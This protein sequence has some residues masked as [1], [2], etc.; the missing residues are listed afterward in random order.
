MALN[1]PPTS[2]DPRAL[3]RA[4]PPPTPAVPAAQRVTDS[5]KVS[6][7]AA[8]SQQ[9]GGEFKQAASAARALGEAVARVDADTETVGRAAALVAEIAGAPAEQAPAVLARLDALGRSAEGQAAGVDRERLGL[10]GAPGDEAI[11]AARES[12]A[13]SRA[14]LDARRAQLEQEGEALAAKMAGRQQP[15]EASPDRVQRARE[16]ISS[17]AATAVAAQAAQLSPA[18]AELLR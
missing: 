13:R 2:V 7:A 3:D 1:I 6:E 17:D 15:S 4:S 8:A 14:D 18:A 12:L 5:V 9:G 10:A 16:Q 11:R